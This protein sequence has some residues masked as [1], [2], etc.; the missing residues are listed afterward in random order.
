MLYQAD[1]IAVRA[2]QYTITY[3]ASFQI[4]G[5][6]R[7]FIQNLNGKLIILGWNEYAGLDILI[8][9]TLLAWINGAGNT[10][11]T[12]VALRIIRDVLSTK[13]Q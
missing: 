7:E 9:L 4:H 1:E 5:I 12:R 8:V 11:L 10:P 2:I 13:R 3:D 6:I